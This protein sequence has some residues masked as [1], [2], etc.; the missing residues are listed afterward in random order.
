[1]GSW[2]WLLGKK[3]EDCGSRFREAGATCPAC[4]ETCRQAEEKAKREAEEAKRKADNL[5]REAEV[6]AFT[7]SS[8]VSGEASHLADLLRSPDAETRCEAVSRLDAMLSRVHFTHSSSTDLRLALE[9][10][11]VPLLSVAQERGRVDYRKLLMAAIA[12]GKK[13]ADLPES[14]RA[15][16]TVSAVKAAG[17]LGTM[18]SPWGLLPLINICGSVVTR[19]TQASLAWVLIDCLLEHWT[20][21]ALLLQKSFWVNSTRVEQ[22]RHLAGQFWVQRS[23]GSE[24]PERPAICDSCASPIPTGGGC[25]CNPAQVATGVAASVTDVEWVNVQWQPDL[26]CDRCFEMKP[27]EPW[28]GGMYAIK[29]LGGSGISTESSKSFQDYLRR[30]P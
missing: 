17:I 8:L 28:D 5:K 4:N 30:K 27:Y 11:V 7:R 19:E 9:E 25:I 21:D 24:N 12:Q 29:A 16:F 6:A 23:S 13:M 26:V 2:D 10:T 1:M 15:P 3:C 18:R 22:A 20:S 14:D